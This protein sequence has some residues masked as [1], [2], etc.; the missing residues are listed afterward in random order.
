MDATGAVLTAANWPSGNATA[1]ITLT[2]TDCYIY[3]GCTGP[4]SSTIAHIG[5]TSGGSSDTSA[6]SVPSP[7]Q[8]G[9][10]ATTAT[11]S[12]QAST[13][14]VGV[15]GYDVRIAGGSPV[16]IGNVLTYTVSG[17]SFPQTFEVRARDAAGNLSAFSA[18]ITLNVSA[19]TVSGTFPSGGA[20]PQPAN[21]AVLYGL[22][23][24]PVVNGQGT[25]TGFTNAITLSYTFGSNGAFTAPLP[26]G[27]AAGNKL[28]A[29]IFT[30]YSFNAN[31]TAGTHGGVVVE[32]TAA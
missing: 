5:F 10:T 28:A 20:V 9:S 12:W 13:D 16:S 14:N 19:T 11:A 1:D 32:A 30:Q 26:A 22:A 2:G 18:P 4:G 8:T 7:S 23:G 3:A 6:P 15:S 21:G 25:L 24:K 29:V 31:P 17:G 27:Y